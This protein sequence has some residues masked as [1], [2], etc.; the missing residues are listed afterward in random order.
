[1]AATKMALIVGANGTVGRT[2][3]KLLTLDEGWDVITLS[4]RAPK[5]AAIGR[6]V[7]VDIYDR[8]ALHEIGTTLRTV[9]HVFYCARAT[10]SDPIEE[11][12]V[13]L[14]MFSNVL[15]AV[16]RS[17]AV[18]SH[19]QAM[20][21]TKWYGCHLGPYRTPALEDNSRHFPPNFYYGQHD[22]LVCR[23]RSTGW[24]WSTLRPHT[25]WG[26]TLG[27]RHSFIVLLAAYATIC[28]HLGLPLTF[29]GTPACFESVSQ[30]TDA[31]LLAKAC[32]WA[33]TTPACA[34]NS[35]NITNGDV[36]RWRYIWPRVADFFQMQPG[37]VQTMNLSQRASSTA[38]IWQEIAAR[39]RLRSMSFDDL[40]DWGY[41]DF[42]LRSDFDDISGTLK[43]RRCGFTEFVE[44]EE[45]LLRLFQR[46]RE[47]RIIP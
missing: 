16:E 36:F 25:V 22:L 28:R 41:F 8:A 26:I 10:A 18:L 38:V 1:M 46:L 14:L 17:S 40:G 24:T 11:E 35:F 27:Y 47:A 39:H 9:T 29:P 6:S 20:H 4:R 12:R 23:Q 31:D 15:D 13:N 19:V 42:T 3:A 37:P 34:N 45:A 21:G 7:S 32:R 2:L 5:L 33:A 30:S 43:A 44:S